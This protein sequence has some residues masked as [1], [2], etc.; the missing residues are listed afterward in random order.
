MP[1]LAGIITGLVLKVP[2][3]VTWLLLINIILLIP[4]WILRKRVSYRY[5]WIPGISL[6]ITLFALG[7][8]NQNYQTPSN[9]FKHIVNQE[10]YS[11]R[12]MVRLLEDIAEKENSNKAFANVLFYKTDSCWKQAFGK[13]ILYFEKDSFS[14]TLKYGDILYADIKLKKV[15]PPQNPGEFDYRRYLANRG[16]YV[17]AYVNKKNWMF[18]GKADKNPVYNAG[19]NIRKKF[20][21]IFRENGITGEEYAV[22]SALLLGYDNYLD[23]EMMKK[24]SGAGAMHI[25]CISGLHVGIIY[26]IL[27]TLFSFLRR[28]RSLVICRVILIMGFIWLYALITGLSPS[29]LRASTM[30]SFILVGN[31]LNR[32]TSIYNSL[33]ASAFF[34][35]LFD[36]YI[37]TEVGFQL[38][39]LAV[40]GIVITYRPVYRLLFVRSIILDRIWAITVVSFSATLFTFP[41]SV[42]YFHQF[43]VLFLVSNLIAIPASTI[44]IYAGLLVLA[45]S[46][47]HFM[48]YFFTKILIWTVKAL[49]VS[50][51]FIESLPFSTFSNISIGFFGLFLLLLIVFTI[52]PVLTD[53]KPGKLFLPLA[54]TVIFLSMVSIQK[55]INLSQ[56]KLII[57]S[58]PGNLAVDF[59]HG[60]S[61]VLLA[62]S[63]FLSNRKNMDYKIGGN[64][65]RNGIKET[66]KVEIEWQNYFDDFIVKKN[67]FIGFKIL[68][69]FILDRDFPGLNVI[70]PESDL[71]ILSG[72]PYL[73]IND[74]PDRLKFEKLIF[75]PNNSFNNIT[76]W[77]NEC[78]SLGINYHD[79]RKVGAFK[80][81]L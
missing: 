57:Y 69:L 49:Y 12:Y 37:I 64:H 48:A 22:I 63:G 62:D 2:W 72:N 15:A 68:R 59:I 31:S 44:I 9:D 58:T 1:F 20:L 76:K 77:S 74:L 23:P 3:N 67:S 70:I 56:N 10:M 35:M 51:T 54:L 28:K 19:Y 66:K 30:F 17:T 73:R 36:P 5:R 32:R 55:W 43:P 53:F 6:N 60:R 38:S 75:A 4:L 33:A 78:D 40:T 18:T 79:V 52:I 27:S 24:F 16:V 21:G 14:G 26:V 45:F 47:I 46:S 41:L 39:Y 11:D 25:L 13:V 65:I 7:I 81:S 8:L 29:V 50:V 71:V 61:S 34:L 80:I 42:Y